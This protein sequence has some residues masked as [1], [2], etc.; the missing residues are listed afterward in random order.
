[1]T[2]EQIKDALEAAVKRLDKARCKHRL[3]VPTELLD[4]VDRM[5]DAWNK[6]VGE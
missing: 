6:G 2:T 5:V 4:A 3:G 1:M